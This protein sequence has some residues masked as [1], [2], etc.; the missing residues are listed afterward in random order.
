[1]HAH[2]SS[3]C[4][5]KSRKITINLSNLVSFIDKYLEQEKKVAEKDTITLNIRGTKYELLVSQ[6]DLI[7]ESRLA[8]L[9]QCVEMS[10]KSKEI[11]HDMFKQEKL[12]DSCNENFNEF[13]YNRDP[14]AI[15]V[16]LNFYNEKVNEKKI[17]L[18]CK[19][20]CPHAIEEELRYWKIANYKS[21]LEPCCLI[22]LENKRDDFEDEKANEKAIL[23]KLNFREDFG[24]YFFP[25]YREIAW[26]VIEKPKS[27]VYAK[28]C[29]LF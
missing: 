19:L 9:K 23:D 6:L 4:A 16:V 5:Y 2:H 22:D 14:Q 12:G 21:Y 8:R 1:M 13:F 10:K 15:N 27:S 7:P 3:T 17:H 18:N 28:V 26:D 25:A 24:K 20:L 11:A 29:R